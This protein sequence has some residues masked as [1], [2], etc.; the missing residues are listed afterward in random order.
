M[1]VGNTPSYTNAGFDCSKWD[2]YRQFDA[3]TKAGLMGY[4]QANMDALQNWF[5]WTWKIGLSDELGYEP[6]PFW[7]YKKGLEEGWIPGDPRVAGGYC[8]RVQN[9]GG[10][11]VSWASS[12][13][14]PAS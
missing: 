12:R 1:G 3:E 14:L 5:F 10:N 8:G 9:V 13:T 7:H 4:G 2:D 6:S 11:Q